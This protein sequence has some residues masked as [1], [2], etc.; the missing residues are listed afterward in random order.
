MGGGEQ[1]AQV[2]VGGLSIPDLKLYG[3]SLL[4]DVSDDDGSGLLVRSEKVADQEVTSCEL[5]PLLI[6][7]DP[8]MQGALSLGTFLAAQLTEDHL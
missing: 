2:L 3:L 4:N 6:H 1:H 8:D 7:R 5:S